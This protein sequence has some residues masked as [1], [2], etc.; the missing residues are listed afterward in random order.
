MVK[1]QCGILAI[2]HSLITI[3]MK[4]EPERSC[5]VTR[6]A[7]AKDEL[8][9]FLVGPNQQLVPDLASK[10]P[11]RGIY[12][13]ASKLMIAEAIAKRLFSKA[14]KEQ[15]HIPDGLLVTLEQLMLRRVGDALSMARKAGQVVTGFEKV[16]AELKKGSVEAL[17]HAE[18]AGEDGIKKLAF[19]TGPI[20]AN[21]PRS[22]LCEVVG[23]EN[24]VHVAVTHG[25]AA[26]FFIEQA[27]R[28]TLFLA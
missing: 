6:E 7:K 26:A 17:I 19:Y 18:D 3:H 22:L 24:A 27:R 25:A 8:I 16:E 13:S 28:F 11:G 1:R 23:R 4:N 5:I 14:A 9:R 15:V 2:H 20:F 21:L 10:L 12:V